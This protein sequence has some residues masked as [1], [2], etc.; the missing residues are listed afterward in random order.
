MSVTTTITQL[1]TIVALDDP[2]ATAAELT[3]HKAASLAAL[4]TAGFD[5]PDGFVVTTAGCQALLDATGAHDPD[6]GE[7]RPHGPTLPATFRS[8]LAAALAG[9]GDAPVAVRSSGVSEDLA[10][11]SFAGQYETVLEVRGL[12]ETID[13][14]H[15]CLGS[16]RSQRAAAYRAGAGIDARAPMAVLVQRLIAGDA[17]GVV[18]SANP[19]T[20]DRDEVLVS[21]VRGLGDRL[22]SGSAT[23]DEWLVR[24]GSA[25]CVGTPE[26]AIDAEQACRIAELAR[27]VEAQRG[28]PQDLEWALTDDRLHLLQARPITALPQPPRFEVPSEGFWGKDTEHYPSPMTPFGASVYLPAIDAAMPAVRD[29][30]GIPFDGFEQISLGGEV[31]GRMIPPGGKDRPAPP[32]WVLAIACRLAPPLRWRVRAAQRALRDDLAGQLARRWENEWR[33]AFRAEAASLRSLDLSGLT[34]EDLLDHLDRVTDLLHRGE[35]VHFRIWGAY[36]IAMYELGLVC[37]ELL[38]WDATATLQLLAGNSAAAAAPT[39]ALD[40]LAD[41]IAGSATALAALEDPSGNVLEALADADPAIAERFRIYLDQF[42]HRPAASYDPGVATL[43]E[44]PELL[45]A[46]VRDRVRTAAGRPGRDP[47]LLGRARELLA[48]RPVEEQERFERAHAAAVRI[49]PT[50]EDN[51]L[52]V[53]GEPSG[54]LRYAALEIGRRLVQRGG[55]SRPDDAVYLEEGELRSA[56]RGDRG[57]LRQIVSRRR[58]E[59]AW[60][61][62]HPGPASYGPEP[63]PPPD[64]RGLPPALRRIVAA[65]L[66]NTELLNPPITETPTGALVAGLPGSPGTHTGAVRIVRGE[67]EFGRVRPG[68]V[69][70]CPTTSP[71]WSVLFGQAGALVTDHG[72]LLSHPAII[73]REHHIPA[74]LATGDA[75]RRLRDGQLVTVDGTRGV[76]SSA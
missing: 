31:Y 41:G 46:L 74:V 22:V 44:Q 6:T 71:V 30:F 27:A 18:F 50:R 16:A 42:G 32:W 23:P 68:D 56:V 63:G 35:T 38:G 65:L 47:D 25:I 61:A 48:V 45:A 29:D 9:L 43:A 62:A 2:A 52:I 49:Y 11:A 36:A 69:L 12:D 7:G 28:S 76:V 3:G 14:I 64:L 51:V 75:T 34:D 40:E 72:G 59:Q 5:V 1:P 33:D 37:Q 20:G 13:A 21:A 53:D 67:A 55:L 24:D 26:Q 39:C 54:L 4:K 60:V 17:A 70:V 19:V 73:A 8:A 10:D 57:D 66:W 15:R 58:A